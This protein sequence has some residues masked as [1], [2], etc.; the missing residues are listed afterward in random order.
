MAESAEELQ[1]I[2][3]PEEETP[4]APSSAGSGLAP[5]VLH[6]RFQIDPATPI[7]ELDSPS[8]KAYAAEDR[9]EPDR[10]VFA[11]ICTPGLP[12]RLNMLEALRGN[13]VPGMLPLQDWG[14]VDWPPL[15]QRC[16]AVIFERPLGGRLAATPFGA[17]TRVTEQDIARRVIEPAVRTLVR[18]SARGL[19]HR[20]IRPNNMYFMDTERREIVLGDCVTSPPGFDQPM[21]FETVERAMTTPGGRGQ[22]QFTEDLYA[23]GVSLAFLLMGRNPAHDHSPE[24][25]LHT[26]VERGSYTA[27]LGS[28][29]LPL[30]MIEPG[31]GLLNDDPHDRWSFEEIQNWLAGARRSPA[32]RRATPRAENSMVFGGREHVSP[33]TLAHALA[34]NPGDAAPIIRDGRLEAWLRR[35]LMDSELA[36]NV[37]NAVEIARAH[38]NDAMGSNDYLVSK[39]CTLLDPAGPIRYRGMAFMPEAYGTTL[40]VELMRRGEVQIP[41]E[42]VSRDIPA[43]WIAAQPGP[44][45]P[46]TAGLE[47]T[48]AEYRALLQNTDIGYGIE[49]CLYLSNPGLPCQ[50]PLVIQDYASD[51]TELLH[52]LD[53]AAGREDTASRPMD[54]HIAAFIGARARVDVG[55]ELQGL[56]HSD[57]RVQAL[58]LLNLYA[59]LQSAAGIENLYAFASWVGGHLGPAITSYSNRNTR[60]ELEREMPRLVRQG[61]L[62]ELLDLIDNPEKRQ[63]D[64]DGYQLAEAQFAAA[65]AE[66]EEIT[67]S[68]TSRA[69]TA[70]SLGQ[71]AAAMGSLL[72]SM[73]IICITFLVST[74]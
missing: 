49:R 39:I 11:L 20:A 36:D 54:R 16:L 64:R 3:V 73:V 35:Q 38:Q 61:S 52:A 46:V 67:V 13:A 27:V 8:A 72:L 31:R 32:P 25:I 55:N 15:G 62:P 24:R 18:L 21:I 17:E 2:E 63:M 29:R 26:K 37:L 48:F 14:G 57:N 10:R 53:T 56:A 66:I 19:T 65:D 70:E 45:G 47:R 23:L 43:L 44:R 5:V 41:A 33:R 58:A 9:R 34:Q 68:D 74:W 7:A 59:K 60:R 12:P 50:S 30:T 40:A 71:Q 6:D 22:G 28:E 51:T 4:E 42:V 69:E 1:D